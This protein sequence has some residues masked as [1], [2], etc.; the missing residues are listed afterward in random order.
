MHNI[1]SY[2]IILENGQT[3]P[4]VAA[5]RR[6]PTFSTSDDGS[7]R[8]SS[9]D[10]FE[11]LSQISENPVQTSTPPRRSMHPIVEKVKTILNQVFVPLNLCNCKIKF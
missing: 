3:S 5:S 4:D 11:P 10:V 6:V 1:K 9:P 8:Q 2:E 7:Q